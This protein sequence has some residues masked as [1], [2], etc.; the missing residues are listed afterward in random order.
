MRKEFMNGGE[1]GLCCRLD[2]RELEDSTDCKVLCTNMFG[3]WF[4][5]K[6]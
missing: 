3:Y 2:R 5:F 6:M 1:M 4:L